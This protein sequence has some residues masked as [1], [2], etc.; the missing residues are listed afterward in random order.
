[1]KHTLSTCAF[2]VAALLAGHALAGDHP[3][4]GPPGDMMHSDKD[5]DG[6][7]SRAE[8]TAAATE[9]TNQWFDKLDQNKDGFISQE[10]V[11]QKRGQMHEKVDENFADADTNKDGQLSLD[12]AQ[13]K[14]PRVADRFNTLD[15]DKNG[16]LSREELQ[17]GPGHQHSKES[18]KEPKN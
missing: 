5:G 10:E 2:A 8:A 13:A 6:R 14:M 1:M 17:R 12:E 15:K 16:Q 18:K 3:H 4:G 11:K 7:V 9:R